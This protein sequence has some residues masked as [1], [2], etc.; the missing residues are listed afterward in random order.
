[1]DETDGNRRRQ[2]KYTATVDE[3]QEI[4]GAAETAGL[5]VSTY[6]RQAALEAPTAASA[7]AL[8]R[9]T[10]LLERTLARLDAIAADAGDDAVDL[11][12]HRRLAGIERMLSLLASDFGK[13]S[14]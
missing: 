9:W 2:Y 12:I 10:D 4:S 8:I 6:V 14:R 11:L 3:Y 5:S 7:D 1:M 13:A